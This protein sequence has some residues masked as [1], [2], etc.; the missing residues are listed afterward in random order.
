[1]NEGYMSKVKDEMRAEY[2]REDLGKGVRGKYFAQ[3]SLHPAATDLFQFNYAETYESTQ[4]RFAEWLES[5]LAIAL[6]E[7][8]R[9][10]QV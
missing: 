7:W 10:L 1:M 4:K 6:A 3:V 8:K 2:R 9:S 5:S